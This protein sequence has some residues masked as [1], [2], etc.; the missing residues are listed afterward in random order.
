M[1]KFGGGRGGGSRVVPVRTGKT[2]YKGR[3]T[4]PLI[5]NIS[6]MWRK[7]VNFTHI[8]HFTLGQ[9]PSTHSL[10]KWPVLSACPDDLE[11]RKISCPC[12]GSNP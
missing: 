7:V 4:T 8:G 3:S 5:L 1:Y 9:N 10:G 12:K 11:K 6:S 2:A